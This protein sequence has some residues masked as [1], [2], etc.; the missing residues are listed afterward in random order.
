M[1]VCSLLWSDGN[2]SFGLSTKILKHF[3]FNNDLIMFQTGFSSISLFVFPYG[4]IIV[5]LLKSCFFL[6]LFCHDK[7]VYP[8]HRLFYLTEPK[9]ST[10]CSA[11]SFGF[12]Y[13]YYYYNFLWW[14]RTAVGILYDF[15]RWIVFFPHYRTGDCMVMWKERTDVR[16]NS[17]GT[18]FVF[19]ASFSIMQSSTKHQ[20]YHLRS[21]GTH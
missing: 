5:A 12:Y 1:F 3:F 11:T 16:R 18:S 20:S 8:R 17:F 15:L 13:W 9:R 2:F 4:I 14:V 6:S 10:T 19:C 7:M 21:I